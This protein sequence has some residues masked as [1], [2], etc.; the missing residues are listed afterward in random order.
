LFVACIRF[1]DP[2]FLPLSSPK[3]YYVCRFTI[4][5]CSSPICPFSRLDVLGA[6]SALAGCLAPPTFRSLA[7][8]G[9]PEKQADE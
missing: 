1:P 9:Q 5:P 6:H 3:S 8:A 4:L 2:L 7:V